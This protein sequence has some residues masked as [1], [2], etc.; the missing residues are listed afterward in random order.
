MTRLKG[1]LTEDELLELWGINKERLTILRKTNKLPYI[2]L[3]EWKRVYLEKSIMDWLDTYEE[4][5]K[6]P[7]ERR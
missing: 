3:S 4:V 6:T 5:Y 7:E 1:M 2:E